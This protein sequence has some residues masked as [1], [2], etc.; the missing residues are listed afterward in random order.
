[1]KNIVYITVFIFISVL[2]TAWSGYV[3]SILWVW[4]VSGVFGLPVLNIPTSIG[5]MIVSRYMTNGVPERKD[6]ES[7]AKKDLLHAIIFGFMYPLL[8][9]FSG[10]IVT[11]FL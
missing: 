9:L 11:F 5:L 10:W 3:F 1:M 6:G 2:I 8:A 7:D 4:F